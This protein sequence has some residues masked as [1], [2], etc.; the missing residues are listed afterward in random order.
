MQ[1]V[2]VHIAFSSSLILVCAI[3]AQLQE[4]IGKMFPTDA[5]FKLHLPFESEF[6]QFLCTKCTAILVTN[7]KVIILIFMCISSILHLQKSVVVNVGSM[8]KYYTLHESTLH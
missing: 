8:E 2:G 5:K 1:N 7:R 6:L 3:D 4:K